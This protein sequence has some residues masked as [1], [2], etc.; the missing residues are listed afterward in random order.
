MSIAIFLVKSC[1]DDVVHLLHDDF[2][3]LA[4]TL[5]SRDGLVNGE[6]DG[7]QVDGFVVATEH[8]EGTVDGHRHDGKSDFV[9]KG[10]S[11]FLEFAH[12][13]SV[14]ACSLGE[15]DHRHAF[16]QCFLCL[17]DGLLHG[18]TTVAHVDVSRLC[19][20]QSNEWN[21]AEVFLHHPL[22]VMPQ[23]AVDEENVE[24]ALVIGQEYV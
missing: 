12:L 4:L 18:R 2:G 15:D 10:E 20:S 7:A 24:V 23:I 11:P 21:L 1:V 16:T 6:G 22:E 5:F 3:L 9:G 8:I 17:N 14:C 13:S 19:A